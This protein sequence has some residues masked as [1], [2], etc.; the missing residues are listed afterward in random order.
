MFVRIYLMELKFPG[1]P[2][3]WLEAVRLPNGGGIF[4]VTP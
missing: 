3:G 2:E 4:K 1:S